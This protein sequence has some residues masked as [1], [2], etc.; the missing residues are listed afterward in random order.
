MVHYGLRLNYSDVVYHALQEFSRSLRS[1]QYLPAVGTDQA[2]VLNQRIHC[3]LIN[4]Y[5]EQSVT[6]YVESDGIAGSE[7]HRTESG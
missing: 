6:S 1:H 5:I 4:R 3:P 7:C 2:A